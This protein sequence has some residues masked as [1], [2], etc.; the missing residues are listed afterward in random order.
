MDNTQ[1]QLESEFLAAQGDYFH[2]KLLMYYE[3]ALQ[4]KY[5]AKPDEIICFDFPTG[6]YSIRYEDL[7]LRAD[8]ETLEFL[9][10]NNLE[11]IPEQTGPRPARSKK[12]GVHPKVVNKK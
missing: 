2:A 5:K 6:E 11:L 3:N 10:A 7:K 1:N 4:D 8:E 12:P 9:D